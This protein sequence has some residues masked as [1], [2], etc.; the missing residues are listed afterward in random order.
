M[1]DR[2]GSRVGMMGVSL[3]TTDDQ[4]HAP[5]GPRDPSA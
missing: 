2:R 1:I 3:D 5:P 4:S